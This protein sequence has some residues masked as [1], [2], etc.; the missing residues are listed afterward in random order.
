MNGGF[1]YDNKN[2]KG[3][4]GY[5]LLYYYSS[6]CYSY[7]LSIIIIVIISRYI[8]VYI[9]ICIYIVNPRLSLGYCQFPWIMFL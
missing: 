9:Y 2:H 3:I 6:Y 4:R 1:D 8:S 5:I 7:Y